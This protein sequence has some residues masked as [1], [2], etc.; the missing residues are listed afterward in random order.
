MFPEINKFDGIFYDAHN[1][2]AMLKTAELK[3]YIKSGGVFTYYNEEVGPYNVSFKDVQY[4]VINV[5]SFIE[6][7]KYFKGNEYY[8]PIVNF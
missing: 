5:E 1:D 8:L 7:C 3:N 2:N 6:E 4:E